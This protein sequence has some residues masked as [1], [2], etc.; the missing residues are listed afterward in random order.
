M[1]IF[2]FPLLEFIL[3]DQLAGQHSHRHIQDAKNGDFRFL[4][5]VHIGR[6]AMA[7]FYPHWERHPL[8]DQLADLTP[9]L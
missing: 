1:A 9:L 2:R 7:D 4:L 6:P 8:A 5:L 3:A